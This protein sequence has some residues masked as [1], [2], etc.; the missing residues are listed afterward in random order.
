M[1]KGKDGRDGVRIAINY[2][3]LNRFTVGDAT[4]LPEI[5]DII[6]KVGAARY[7]SLFDAKS[8]YHQYPMKP[9]DQ[10]LSAFVC[11]SGLC[12]WTRAPFGMKGSGCTFVRAINQIL[13]P[14]KHF[15]KAYVDDM[16]VYSQ[17]WYKHLADIDEYLATI[18]VSG[19]TLNL[20]K[21]QFAQSEIKYVGHIIGS[22]KWRADSDRIS[23]VQNLKKPETKKNKSGKC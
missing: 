6:Q 19:L 14:I 13:E 23:T 20:K 18:K 16:A 11:D 22:G 17:E 9:E 15:T 1:L 7:I 4:P 21:Y 3:Y 8:G 2:Q 10:W 5:S 12:E